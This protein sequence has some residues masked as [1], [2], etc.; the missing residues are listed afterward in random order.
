MEIKPLT[1]SIIQVE[2]DALIV[3]LFKGVTAP[4]GATGAV[5][6]ALGG[7]LSEL[8]AQEGFEGKPGQILLV[9]TQGMLPAKKV[10]VVGLGEAEK[11]DT[12]AARRASA[13]AARR[14]REVKAVKVASIIHGAGIGGMDPARSA[15]ATVEGAVI[16]TYRFLSYKSEPD[17]HEI[18]EFLLVEVDESKSTAVRWGAERGRI[19]GEAVNYARDLVNAP[20]CKVTP[21][22]LADFGAQIAREGKLDFSALEREDARRLGMGAYLAVAQG[23]DE[24]PKFIVLKYT[25]S[26]PSEKTV[27][28]IGKGVTFDSGGLSLKDSDSM[29]TM[30]DD[31]AGAAAMLAIM[32]AVAQLKPT[33]SVMGISAATENMPSGKAVKPGDIARAMNGKTIEIDN[34]D[35]EGRLTLSDALCYAVENGAD[36]LIDLATLTGACV[37]AL[38]REISGAF[39]NDKKLLSHL[40]DASEISG[41]IIWPMPLHDNYKELFSSDIADM[42]NTG[43][44]EAGATTAALLLQEFTSNKPWAHIDIAGPAFYTKE[45]PLTGKGGTGAGVR[46]L[47]EYLCGGPSRN[48]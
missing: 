38:G 21:S 3:N 16:G 36:E 12:N 1:G 19:V 4:G 32:K 37:V 45:N 41:D 30:K 43:G 31:M 23:T 28:V 22:R 6:K 15:Q 5:D 42:K 18:Q 24:P 2:C 40:M 14:A 44:R 7:L 27:A 20:S 47:I 46:L 9:H 8:I 29:S 25:P 35:A 26:T 10:I 34:T 17:P 33:V 39:V 11:F 48:T 13:A